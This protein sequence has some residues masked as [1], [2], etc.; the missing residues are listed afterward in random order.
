MNSPSVTNLERIA[1]HFCGRQLVSPRQIRQILNSRSMS[2]A[3]NLCVCKCFRLIKCL[4]DISRI[5]EM[6]KMHL[7]SLLLQFQLVLDNIARQK[8]DDFSN[9]AVIT[10][11]LLAAARNSLGGY[12]LGSVCVCSGL[13]TRHS[14]RHHTH[15]SP[16][17]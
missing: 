10:W 16:Q 2:L 3:P 17:W 4:S 9:G 8:G 7:P 11:P 1:D 13:Q 14:C 15:N 12:S 5:R 6:F